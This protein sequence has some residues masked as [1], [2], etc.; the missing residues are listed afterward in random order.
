MY[1]SILRDFDV[2]YQDTD[3]AFLEEAE[4]L[5]FVRERGH[6]IGAEFG[7]FEPEDGSQQIDRLVTLAPKNYFAFIGDQVKKKGFKGVN[8]TPNADWGCDRL[9]DSAEMRR[10]GFRFDADGNPSAPPLAEPDR[11]T[12]A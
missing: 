11:L 7:Q 3:S 10:L 1:D 12:L 6:L 8:L 9:L 4:Y 5:R 2:I